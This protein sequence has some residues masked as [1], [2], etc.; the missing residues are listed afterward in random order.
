MRR[1]GTLGARTRLVV[2]EEPGRALRA[3]DVAAAVGVPV[4]RRLTADPA[5]ARSVDAGLL[6]VRLPRSLRGLDLA[7]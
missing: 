5:V 4:W 2:I 7:A 1:A 3:D 6:A